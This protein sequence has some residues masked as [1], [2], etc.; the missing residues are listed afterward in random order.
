M[1]IAIAREATRTR[2]DYRSCVRAEVQHRDRD[3]HSRDMQTRSQTRHNEG[4]GLDHCAQHPRQRTIAD[5]DVHVVFKGR[6]GRIFFDTNHPQANASPIVWLPRICSPIASALYAL[7][8]NDNRGDPPRPTL[9]SA[10]SRR[11]R[12]RHGNYASQAGIPVATHLTFP[13]R[14]NSAPQLIATLLIRS[15]HP[16]AMPVD[17]AQ[18]VVSPGYQ[19]PMPFACSTKML[20][21]PPM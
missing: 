11:H 1:A 14:E 8:L 10:F 18:A 2:R 12:A 9:F 15:F 7:G 17:E 4:T 16:G 13:R 5:H 6:L 21:Q 3:H 20:S 19:L